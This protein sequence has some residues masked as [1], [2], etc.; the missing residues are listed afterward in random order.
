MYINIY[1]QGSNDRICVRKILQYQFL[2]LIGV[3]KSLA[4]QFHFMLEHQDQSC[5]CRQNS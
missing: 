2:G 5:R 3:Q 4:C 1:K